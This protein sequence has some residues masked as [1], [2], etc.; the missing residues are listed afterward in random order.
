MIPGRAFLALTCVRWYAGGGMGAWDSLEQAS[1]VELFDEAA[2][3]V[4]RSAS[5][6]LSHEEMPSIMSVD[7][8]ACLQ[9]NRWMKRHR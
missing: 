8:T 3:S 5:P 7:T 9:L 6:T 2:P 4:F 1:D